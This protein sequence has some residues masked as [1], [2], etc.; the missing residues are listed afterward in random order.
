MTNEEIRELA[1]RHA[2]EDMKIEKYNK[3]PLDDD[4]D[5]DEEDEEC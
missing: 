2:E 3:N 4:W 1:K 5:W